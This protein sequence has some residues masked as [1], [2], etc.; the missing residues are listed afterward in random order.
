MYEVNTTK[1][2]QSSTLEAIHPLGTV[3]EQFGDGSFNFEP[4][5][6]TCEEELTDLLTEK[7]ISHRLV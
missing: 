2:N 7:G 6:E 3:S 5:D 4:Y 1:A